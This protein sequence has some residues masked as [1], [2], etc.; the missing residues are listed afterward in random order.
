MAGKP[1]K[2]KEKTCD[3]PGCDVIFIGRGKAKYCDEHRKSKYRK[4]LYKRNDNTG[5]GIVII[6]HKECYAKKISLTCELNGCD[7][8]YDV[9][10]I[11]R[12]FEYPSFCEEHRN[13]FKRQMFIEKCVL[14]ES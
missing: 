13:E 4:E 5:D 12:L 14:L 11:P 3:F 8:E 2:L 9:V 1:Q 6:D 10:L 7:H